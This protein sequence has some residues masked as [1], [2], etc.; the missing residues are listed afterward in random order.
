VNTTDVD[1]EM[2][3]EVATYNV[4]RMHCTIHI[5]G[6]KDPCEFLIEGRGPNKE[7]WKPFGGS[8]IEMFNHLGSCIVRA[9]ERLDQL[10]EEAHKTG[11]FH[12]SAGDG[13]NEKIIPTKR[14]ITIDRRYEPF[15]R[16]WHVPKGHGN[17]Q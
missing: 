10:L 13:V 4:G 5:K 7:T 2:Y 16:S 12:V 15:E 14:I 6:A 3:S 9:H 11:F 17:Q 1:L 8:K